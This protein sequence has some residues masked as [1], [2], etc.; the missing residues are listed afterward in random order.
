MISVRR[1]MGVRSQVSLNVS[2]KGSVEVSVKVS[3]LKVH[4]SSSLGFL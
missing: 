2:L 4:G 1:I 3:C